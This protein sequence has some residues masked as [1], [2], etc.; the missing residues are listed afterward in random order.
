MVNPDHRGTFKITQARSHR[1]SYT[2]ETVR[3]QPPTSWAHA[4]G[5]AHAVRPYEWMNRWM[6]GWAD[7]QVK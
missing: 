7:R 2:K 6:D 5:W 4:V 3:R 1:R